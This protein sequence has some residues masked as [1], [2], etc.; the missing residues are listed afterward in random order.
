MD[1]VLAIPMAWFI[2]KGFRKGLIFE[3]SSLVGLV[4]GIYCSIKFS[5]YVST[6]IG[7]EGEYSIL[8]AFFVTFIAVYLL[9]LFLGKCIEGLMKMMKMG[10]M[11]NILGSVFG[12]LKCVCMLSV[13]MYYVVLI[14][15]DKV[16][17]TDKTR[18]QSLFY[19][20]IERT[21]NLLIGTLKDYVQEAKENRVEN[22]G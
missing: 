9:S 6:L 8:V 21:G 10:I 19:Q 17:I 1:I 18:E 15:F 16:I 14:D 12:L 13:V 5:K 4:V 11:N 22:E 20:P 2:Y 3:L 7:I